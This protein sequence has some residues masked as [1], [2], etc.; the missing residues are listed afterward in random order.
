MHGYHPKDKHSYAALLTNQA[1]VP[2][3]IT[4]IPHLHRLM[5]HHAMAPSLRA[6][7]PSAL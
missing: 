5:T 2:E 7:S 1:S 4:A 3:D 6:I